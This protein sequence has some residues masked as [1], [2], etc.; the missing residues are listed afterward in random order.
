MVDEFDLE[1]LSRDAEVSKSA[2]TPE[3][4]EY[5][6]EWET[7]NPSS[8]Q[9]SAAK[10]IASGKDTA[11]SIIET[12]VQQLASQAKQAPIAQQ[13]DGKAED[14]RVNHSTPV[15]NTASPAKTEEMLLVAA[16]VA[17][18]VAKQPAATTNAAGGAS[19]GPTDQQKADG[20][21]GKKALLQGVNLSDLDSVAAMAK[22]GGWADPRAFS[23]DM[24]DMSKIEQQY[25][26][27]SEGS[28]RYLD[29]GYGKFKPEFAAHRGK[30]GDTFTV[31]YGAAPV[32]GEHVTGQFWDTDGNKTPIYGEAPITGYQVKAGAVDGEK[33]RTTL[34]HNYDKDGKF[35]NTSVDVEETFGDTL[36]QMAPFL[37]AMVPGLQ[38]TVAGAVS[39]TTGLG[40]ATSNILAGGVIGGTTAELTGG[41]FGKGFVGGALGQGI[42]LAV[43]SF[44]PGGMVSTDPAI[45][46]AINTGTKSVLTTAAKGGNAQD[47][48]TGA[49]VSGAVDYIDP[50]SGIGLSGNAAKGFNKAA[51]AGLTAAATNK[52]VGAAV[53]GSVIN[54][55]LEPEK[56]KKKG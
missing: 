19:T 55:F 23:L 38:G 25:Q 22:A 4:L 11:D 15:I 45:S 49:V 37:L 12:S 5:L 17:A 10:K 51:S 54:S 13:A 30:G 34:Y 46:K 40:A 8:A 48:L 35:L 1:V 31:T 36:K 33:R 2:M 43:D 14:V 20:S 41:N 26:G 44:N 56:T 47:A 6:K 21:Y 9:S 32:I 50:G 53:K 7:S 29:R 39:S 52:D 18:P 28:D 16:P 24:L 42:G 27:G 3:E